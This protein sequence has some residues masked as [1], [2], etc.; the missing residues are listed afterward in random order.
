MSFAFQILYLLLERL[1]PRRYGFNESH[2]VNFNVSISNPILRSAV[3]QVL[4]DRSLCG[5]ELLYLMA[6]VLQLASHRNK[7]LIQLFGRFCLL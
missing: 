4:L 1:L 3:I 5:H 6:A 7:L 2:H